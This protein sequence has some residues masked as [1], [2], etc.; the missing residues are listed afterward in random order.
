MNFRPPPKRKKVDPP[1][2]SSSFLC[3]P[4]VPLTVIR[5]AELNTIRKAMVPETQNAHVVQRIQQAKSYAVAQAQQ[6]GSTANFKIFDSPFG[7]FMVPV[8][9]TRAEL[10]G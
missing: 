7:N 9:P 10:G 4:G 3:S 2:P 8:I 6:D 5:D 1:I